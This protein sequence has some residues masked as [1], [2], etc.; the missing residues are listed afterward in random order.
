[1]DGKGSGLFGASES[2]NSRRRESCKDG[3]KNQLQHEVQ[4]DPEIKSPGEPGPLARPSTALCKA[5]DTT[6]GR[7][8]ENNLRGRDL[9]ADA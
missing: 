1:M 8:E 6:A 9:L 7:W 5:A 4:E 3:S 2:T